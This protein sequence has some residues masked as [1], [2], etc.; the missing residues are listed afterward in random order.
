MQRYSQYFHRATSSWV[1]FSLMLLLSSCLDRVDIGR[2]EADGSQIVVDAFLSDEPRPH[3]VK[4]MRASAPYDDLSKAPPFSA[5]SVSIAD[6]LGNVQTL[7]EVILGLY[8]TDTLFRGEVGRTYTLHIETRDGKIF[9]STPQTMTPA[10]EIDSIYYDFESF[11]PATAPTRYGFRIYMDAHGNTEEENLLRWRFTGVYKIRGVP[12]GHTVSGPN[13]EPVPA[14]L[15][16]CAICWIYQYENKP[17]VNDGQVA[18]KGRFKKV[19]V[20][21]VPITGRTFYQKYLI[22]IEQMSLSREAFEYF[23]VVENQ[24]EGAGSLFQPPLGVPRTNIFNINGDKTINGIFYVSAVTRKL[25][26]LTR[27]DVEKF[28]SVPIAQPY[29]SSCLDFVNSTTAEPADWN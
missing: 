22:E 3:Y 29:N 28:I 19:D 24:H 20:G 15:P 8:V 5:K 21:Y 16:C 6:D 10:G 23:K 1:T 18:A 2:T 12:E 25:K 9:E 26:F 7:N 4:L 11:K 13:G 17:L 27:A 14:P